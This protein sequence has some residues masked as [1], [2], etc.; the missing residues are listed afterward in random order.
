MS[1]EPF[2]LPAET[3][4]GDAVQ[5]LLEQGVHGAPVTDRD[6]RLAGVVSMMDLAGA[7]LHDQGSGWR[8]G[9]I[10]TRPA[11]TIAPEDGVYE[12]A[13]RMVRLGVHRLVVVDDAGKVRGVLTP[14][15]VLRGIVNLEG[16]FH[17]R[18]A[19]SGGGSDG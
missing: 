6:G 2:C 1:G 14:T 4:V 18:R 11:I 8:T 15:D 12:A 19:R 10:A 13:E 9:D 17:V 16:G 3:T 5:K 7:L